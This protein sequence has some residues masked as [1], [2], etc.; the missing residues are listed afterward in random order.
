M[1]G[2]VKKE[3]IEYCVW[4]RY[5]GWKIIKKIIRTIRCVKKNEVVL[6]NWWRLGGVKKGWHNAVVVGGRVK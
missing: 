4:D 3:N 1:I 5:R 6:S 2:C